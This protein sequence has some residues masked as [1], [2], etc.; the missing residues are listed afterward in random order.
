MAETT[1]QH[2]ADAQMSATRRVLILIS[3]MLSVALYFSSILVAST[4]LPQMQGS[5]SATP[6]EI[7]WTMTFNILAT[8]IA[9]PMTG[10]LTA[11]FGR[12]TVMI[13]STGIFTLA[14]TLCGFATTLEAMI[15]WRIVQGA[16]GAPCVPL[17]Q[18][19]LLDTF[20]PRQHR[21]VLGIYGMGVVL[22][23]IIGPALGGYLA[24]ILNWRW[25]FFLLIPV[26]VA[27]TVG[28]AGTL[29]ADQ[30]RGPV[31]LSWI[32]FILL[33]LA[34]GG[35]Q[36]ALSRGQRLD[37]FESSEIRITL[38]ISV[39]AFYLFLAHSLTSRRPFLD[40]RL[41]LDRNYSLGLALIAI[42]GMLNFTPMV[43]LPPL[44]RV[45]MGYPDVLVGQVVGARGL[46]GLFGFFAVI[47]L[48]RLDPR[49]SVGIGFILQL[50]A[51]IWL[52]RIDLNVTPLELGIN[53]AVQGLSSGI[54]VVALTLVTF[55]N[56]PRERMPEAT[57][58]FHLLRNI[59]A[60]LFISVCVAE[61]VRS[62]GVNYSVLSE[63]ISP[64]NRTLAL[65]WAVGPLDTSSPASLARLSGEISRQAAMIAHL[66]AFGLYS[67]VA[68]VSVPLVL[69][70]RNARKPAA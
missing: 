14:T 9:M 27:A 47:F 20:P 62:T 18:T 4:V 22:G 65:P 50:V 38:F 32:G 19:I 29:A 49:A 26:G 28:L 8:A 53:G 2:A 58:V 55:A 12:S 45:Y 46:G 57:A 59:G 21:M 1:Q 10:W 52:M 36:L 33:S 63:L 16:A 30:K 39:I 51:G 15:V 67:A 68:A 56:I 66:N 24:E 64:Y 5:F 60:S 35:L 34:L 40:L 13:W 54:I 31:H 61:V 23:P 43:L 44:M 17:A 7:S 25:A 11:R 41:L 6:D 70:L 3:A 69:L 37:W 48:T 42:F